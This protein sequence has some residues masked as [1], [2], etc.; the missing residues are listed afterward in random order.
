[1]ICLSVDQEATAGN[2][3]WSEPQS[4]DT[5]SDLFEEEE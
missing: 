4:L 2:G 1:M 3:E 5:I